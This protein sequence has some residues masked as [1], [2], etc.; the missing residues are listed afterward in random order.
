MLIVIRATRK[1]LSTRLSVVLQAFCLNGQMKAIEKLKEIKVLFENCG[2]DEPAKEAEILLRGGLD[3]GAVEVFRDNPELSNEQIRKINGML[4]RRMRGEPFQ[5]IIG[6]EEFMGLKLV[7]GP[8][9]LIPRPETELLAE[10]AVKA[11][12]RETLSV[13]RNFRETES[14]NT[15]FTI[16]DSR[17]TVLDLCTGCGCLALAIAKNFPDIK[18]YGSDISG[19][20]VQYAKKNAAINN[21]SNADFFEGPLFRPFEKTSAGPMFDLI[22]SNPPY[23]ST[24]DIRNLQPEIKDWEPLIALDGGADGLDFYRDIFSDVNRYL[25]DKG[26]ILLEAGFNQA[27]DVREIA[28]GSG[29][30]HIAVI[31]DLAGIER[32]IKAER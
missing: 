14:L 3:I 17:F 12:K 11:V 16:H 30:N 23:I 5:Y 7:V 19:T 8:G 24:G 22:I 29:F 10:Q 21:I 6:Y 26:K 20:A 25:K 1:I 28:I 2:I 4:D 9:V 31:K 27:S 32:I 15:Q 18:V 13:K